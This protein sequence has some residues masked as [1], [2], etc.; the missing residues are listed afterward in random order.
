MLKTILADQIRLLTFRQ[1]MVSIP[2]AWK[3]Y[4]GYALAVTWVVG[5]GRYWD[6]PDPAPWQS[7]GLGSLV[8]LI[9]LSLYLWVVVAPIARRP[10][11]PLLILIFVGMTAAPG[12]LYAI[13]VEKFMAMG[14]AA[15]TNFYFL[16]V[17]AVWRVSLLLYF[18][19]RAAGLGI[20][21][22]FTATFL[23]LVGIMIL[24]ASLSLEHVTFDL[25]AGI[26]VDEDH[27][28]TAAGQ[29]ASDVTAALGLSHGTT[30]I[31]EILS[32]LASPILLASYLWFLVRK[33]WKPRT[34][35]ATRP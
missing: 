28:R 18:V 16:A 29:V 19:H 4:L 12:I 34:G 1:T 23:P 7:S 11:P 21:G 27:P 20:W 14:T 22:T 6:H 35:S 33:H 17:V 30:H 26:M 5:I 15:K 2:T 3:A 25:M 32:W 13:P 31:L 9:V 24:L 10:L 8:Y